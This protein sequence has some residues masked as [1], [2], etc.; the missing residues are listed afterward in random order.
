M[1][2]DIGGATTDLHYTTDIIR[3]DSE[4]KALPGSSVARY[5]F[6]DLGIVASRDSVLLQLRGHP[7]LYDLLGRIAE[8]DD[9]REMYQA[10]RE[11]EFEPSPRLLSYTCLFI[12]LDRFANGSTP[13]L[14]SADLS[15]VAQIILTGGAAQLLNVSV[16][17]RVVDLFACGQGNPR[18]LI[19]HCYRIWVDGITWSAI[20]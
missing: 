8:D 7:R 2:L 11:G 9:I 12:A 14:P 13:G 18:I 19:D 16:A 4:E 5:V 20:R 15:K 17:S 1:L 3:E 6:T 10:L